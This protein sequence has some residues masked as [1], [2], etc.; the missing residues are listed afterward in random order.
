MKRQTL[1]FIFCLLPFLLKANE[2]ILKENVFKKI[3]S[4]LQ[5]SKEH[6]NN[7]EIEPAFETAFIALSESAETDYSQGKAIAYLNLA[8]ALNYLG[9]YEKTLEYLSLAEKEPYSTNEKRILY[10]I[11]RI[12][13]QIFSY[14]N[15]DGQA[16]REFHKC[17]SLAEKLDDKQ[18]INYGLSMSYENL[19][20]VYTKIDKT[21]SAFY[22]INKNKEVLESMD[23]SYIYRSL[24]NLYST[25]GDWFIK[26]GEYDL[27]KDNLNKALKIA[28][29]YQYPYLSRT[30]TYMGDM[31]VKNENQDSA[32]Y[33]YNKA[34]DNL[35]S[36]KIKG[37]L[38]IVYYKLS[39]IYES[40]GEADSVIIYREKKNLI[41]SEL[42][43]EREKSIGEALSVFLNEE[44]KMHQ[45]HNKKLLI[46]ISI[47]SIIVLCITVIVWIIT[48]R[49]YLE[50]K[51][52][53]DVQ[54]VNTI[55]EIE[56]I[57]KESQILEKKVNESFKEVINIAKN[58]DPAFLKRFQE[59]YPEHSNILLQMHPNLTNSE[60]TLCALI[61]LKFSTKDIANFTF[62]EHRSV[63]TKKSRLRKKLNLPAGYN[64]EK[65][66][67]ELDKVEF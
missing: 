7:V 39:S 47:I 3:D 58:N 1:L 8:Q 43:K 33:Y 40:L 63:Q 2:N 25:L 10:E 22:F 29:K 19:T 5:V 61:Y 31:Y 12:R 66:L 59:V 67:Q 16:I 44:R 18:K 53:L 51:N 55:K 11:S 4:L 42:L 46:V 62:V 32:L 28:E 48:K 45:Q 6:I 60:L 20:V 56:E 17:I 9:N 30:Y 36:T 14:M 52:K 65:Y 24:V 23:E 64:L 34:L 38:G 37:E 35:E 50:R 49:K 41:E 26:A 57:E 15:L 27:T 54:L 21:D 13:G